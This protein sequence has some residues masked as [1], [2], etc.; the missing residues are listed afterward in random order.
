[1][2]IVRC[3]FYTKLGEIDIIAKERDEWVF[4]EV[5]GRKSEQFGLPQEAVNNKKQKKV[6]RVALFFLQKMHLNTETSPLRFDV[7]SFLENEGINW[8]KNAY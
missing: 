6:K 3:N 2:K 4:V 1:L 8:I 7:I 5:K